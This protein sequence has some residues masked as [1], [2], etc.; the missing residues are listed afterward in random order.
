MA[1]EPNGKATVWICDPT[2]WSATDQE[3]GCGYFGFYKPEY[4][5]AVAIRTCPACG[6]E[7]FYVKTPDLAVIPV[8]KNAPEG[9]TITKVVQPDDEM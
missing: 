2:H 7:K 4:D 1:D 8:I 3:R 9:M 5:I 6:R